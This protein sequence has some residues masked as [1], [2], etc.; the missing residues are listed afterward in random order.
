[1]YQYLKTIR[2]QKLHRSSQQRHVLK[3]TARQPNKIQPCPI[4]RQHRDLPN[5]S[6]HRFM[7]PGRY[8]AARHSRAP[9][10]DDGA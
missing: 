6:G 4:A 10:I 9:V 8:L 5:P 3:D 2:P 1:V 7:E